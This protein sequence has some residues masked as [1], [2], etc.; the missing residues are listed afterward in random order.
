MRPICNARPIFLAART[1]NDLRL[2]PLVLSLSDM[3]THS[4]SEAQMHKQWVVVYR[5]GGTENFRW[6]RTVRFSTLDEAKACRDANERM[7]YPSM[8][9]LAHP[10]EAIGLPETFSGETHGHGFWRAGVEK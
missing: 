5:T 10:S 8:I 4:N 2:A 9:E 7:G 1:P 6:Q 3:N